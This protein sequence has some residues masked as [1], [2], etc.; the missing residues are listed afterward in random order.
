MDGFVH[1]DFHR[2]AKTFG[3]VLRGGGGAA[4]AVAHN[5]EP[6]VD[7]WGGERDSDGTPWD[8]D[9]VALS[10]STTRELSRRSQHG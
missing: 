9:T 8:R 4:V 1:P 6:V 5:G 7:L 2:V 3:R 10:F